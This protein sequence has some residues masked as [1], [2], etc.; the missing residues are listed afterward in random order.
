MSEDYYKYI[1]GLMRDYDLKSG[2]RPKF[3]SFYKHGIIFGSVIF[4]SEKATV[5]QFC[6]NPAIYDIENPEIVK[7]LLLEKLSK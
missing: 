7:K 2:L 3:D 1:S 4:I 5:P 6:Y